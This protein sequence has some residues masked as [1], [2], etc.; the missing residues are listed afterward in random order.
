MVTSRADRR[1]QAV[2]VELRVFSR[3][4]DEDRKVSG[5]AAGCAAAGI[6][7]GCRGQPCQ[8]GRTEQLTS[9]APWVA[10]FQPASLSGDDLFPA[11]DAIFGEGRTPSSPTP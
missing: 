3:V 7:G 11:L 9:P 10:S 8:V 6:I 5:K 2:A 4:S 1:A